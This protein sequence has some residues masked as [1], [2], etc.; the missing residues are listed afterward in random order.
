MVEA[1]PRSLRK[2]LSRQRQTLRELRA[3]GVS[4]RELWDAM[5]AVRADGDLKPGGDFEFS[6]ALIVAELADRGEFPTGVDWDNIF[7]LIEKLMPLIE[8][9][10]T[11]CV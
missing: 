3:E 2:E 10:A 9:W 1:M 8:M 7:R 11:M 6:A 4:R 5:R